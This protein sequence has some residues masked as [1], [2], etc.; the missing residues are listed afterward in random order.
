MPDGRTPAQAIDAGDS[1][2]VLRYLRGA[3]LPTPLLMPRAT[4]RSAPLEIPKLTA[5]VPADEINWDSEA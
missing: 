5:D 1:A 2:A 3:D 4:G